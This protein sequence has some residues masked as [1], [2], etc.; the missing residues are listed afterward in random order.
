MKTSLHL[1]ISVVLSVA[2]LSGSIPACAEAPSLEELRYEAF[3]RGGEAI[4]AA[5]NAKSDTRPAV[6]SKAFTEALPARAP[7]PQVSGEGGGINRLVLGGLIT[8]FV[9]S[10][11]L[12]YKYATGPGAS[13]RNCSTCK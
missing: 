4:R 9:V 5:L 2:L 12:I 1:S 10:G 8:G 13:V 7:I 11:I 6:V 3:L